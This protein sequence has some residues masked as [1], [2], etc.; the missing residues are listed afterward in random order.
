MSPQDL[1]AAF[2]LFAANCV[3]YHGA[4]GGGDGPAAGALKPS[5]VNFHVRQ[6]TADRARSVI[7]NGIPGSS[8]PAWKSRLNDDERNLLARY[9]QSLYDGGRKEVQDQ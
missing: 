5:P 4:Q 6:P 1:D 9:V 2:R 3:N 7:Q 8:M